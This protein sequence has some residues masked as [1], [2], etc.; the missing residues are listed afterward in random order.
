M[1]LTNAINA[2]MDGLP[3][4]A[5][6][7]NTFDQGSEFA[8]L[9]KFE[10]GRKRQ[11]RKIKTYYCDPRSPWQKGGVENF[12]KRIRRYLSKDFDIKPITQHTINRITRW[13]NNTSKKC[14]GFMT[15]AEAFFYNCRASIWNVLGELPR[16]NSSGWG[17]GTKN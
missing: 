10:R 17:L 15:P 16:R 1:L 5:T 2:T 11:R 12:N 6:N 8:D 4:A 7:S 13:V 9:L 3:V 14:L